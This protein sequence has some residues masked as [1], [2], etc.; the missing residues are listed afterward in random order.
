MLESDA[1]QASLSIEAAR[2]G[3][4]RDSFAETLLLFACFV[5]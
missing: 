5:I 1:L 3:F 4:H 2:S